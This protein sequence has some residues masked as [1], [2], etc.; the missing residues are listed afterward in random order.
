MRSPRP[1]AWKTSRYSGSTVASNEK[2]RRLGRVSVVSRPRSTRPRRV[3]RAADSTARMARPRSGSA[4]VSV[5][6][7]SP[8][9]RT[10]VEPALA[11]SDP[12]TV[13]GYGPASPGGRVRLRSPPPMSDGSRVVRGPRSLRCRPND[14]RRSTV[15]PGRAPQSRP[16]VGNRFRSSPSSRHPQCLRCVS[17]P[18]F[19]GHPTICGRRR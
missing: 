14:G 5:A 3:E 8:A 7:S 17:R 6:A 16:G 1:V 12:G 19:T 10:V 4:A 11:D 13:L 18:A 15:G 2:Q 9:V